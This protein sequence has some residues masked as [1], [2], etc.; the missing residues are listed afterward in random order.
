M[1]T[2]I[3]LLRVPLII[4]NAFSSTKCGC[5]K[6]CANSNKF[7]FCAKIKNHMGKHKAKSRETWYE[8]EK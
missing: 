2:F 4:L 5:V 7:I 6:W 8:S 1:N 3:N